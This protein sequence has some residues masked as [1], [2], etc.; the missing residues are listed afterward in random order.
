M[1]TL[2][3]QMRILRNS[4]VIL[5]LCLGGDNGLIRTIWKTNKIVRYTLGD[6]DFEKNTSPTQPPREWTY[7]SS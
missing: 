7:S 1:E 4:L 5:D 6:V 2:R 3:L